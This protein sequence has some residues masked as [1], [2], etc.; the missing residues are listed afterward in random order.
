MVETAQ[1]A[2]EFANP[3]LLQESRV[4]SHVPAN[5]S[6]TRIER[7]FSEV[8]H[9][10]DHGQL[11]TAIR[12]ADS[13]RRFTPRNPT[14]ALLYARLLLPGGA[15]AEAIEALAPFD[16]PDVIVVR[17]EALCA[18]GRWNEAVDLCETVLCKFA[19]D[20][21]EH[22]QAFAGLMCSS[23]Q[24]PR[25]SGW[26]GLDS[27]LK[28]IGEVSRGSQLNLRIGGKV[29]QP[30]ILRDSRAR[31]DS[32][33]LQLPP[34]STGIVTAC[35]NGSQL[36]G[37]G[38]T[39]PVDFASGG[40]VYRDGTSIHGEVRC[41]WAPTLPL[42]LA[43]RSGGDLPDRLWLIDPSC[44]GA[45]LLHSVPA[46]SVLPF[47]I[48]LTSAEIALP[49]VE[50]FLVLPDESL[51]PLLGS[52]VETPAPSAAL[53]LQ[54]PPREA[55]DGPEH[56]RPILDIVIPVYSGYDETL[57]CL[58]SVWA[59]TGSDSVEMVVV[60]DASPDPR[61]CELLEQW[62]RDGRI[63]LL[64]NP[65]NRGFPSSANR[66][67]RLHGDRDVVLLNSDT[68]VFD[69]WLERLKRAAYRAED[70]GTVTPLGK[71]DSITDYSLMGND[72]SAASIDR[73]AREVNADKVVELP[74]GVGF[75]LLVRRDCLAETG[76]FDEVNFGRGYGEENDFC[77]RASDRGWRHLAAT[78]VFIEHQG[79]RSFGMAREALLARNGRVLNLLHPGYD[80]LIDEFTAGNSL[81]S[82]R[83]AI[84]IRLLLDQGKP[85]V[86]LT[87]LQL[88]GGVKRHVDQRSL[89]L[90]AAGHTVLVLRPSENRAPPGRVFFSVESLGLKDLIFD[91]SRDS[92]IL[93]EMLQELGLEYIEIH[94]LLDMPS[95][96][97]DLLTGLG[98]PYHV[99]I[100]DYSWICPRLTLVGGNGLYCG[101]PS[102]DQCE[103][104]IQT[105]GSEMDGSVTVEELRLRSARI[106]GRA[107]SVIAP[108]RDAHDRLARYFPN[109]DVKIVPWEAV[110]RSTARVVRVEATLRV[111]ILGAISLQKGHQILLDC[112]RDAA[113]RDLNLEFVVIGYTYDDEPLL[114]TGKVFV[115]GPYREE[116]INSLLDRER[117][118]LA[119]FSSVSPETWCYTLTYAMA[120]GLPIVAFD[121][122]AVAE[123]LL[124]FSAA[125]LLQLSSTPANINDSLLSFM[126][127][128]S[129]SEKQ[130]EAAME[131]CA[132]SAAQ[133]PE[134]E[135]GASVQALSLPEGI[136]SFSVQGGPT[137]PLEAE[138]LALPAL[139]VGVAPAKNPGN[140]EFLTKATALDGWLV[141]ETDMIILKISGGNASLLLTSLR[142][143]DSP[144]LNVDVRRLAV[145]AGSPENEAKNG[146]LESGSIESGFVQ[147]ASG[148]EVQILTHIKNI[149]DLKFI[150]G[151]AG[152]VGQKLW[153]EAFAVIAAGDIRPDLI[154][155]RAVTAEGLETPWLSNQLLCGSRGVGMPIVS[156]AVR[157][158]PE[159]ASQYDCVY[160]G[161][162]LSGAIVGPLT[163]SELCSSE[164][165]G[166]PLEAMELRV[167]PREGPP[168]APSRP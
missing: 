126:E 100:H 21:I 78:D 77:L 86:L 156:Y 12:L 166:D 58:E 95:D 30:A 22:L 71:A 87:T 45:G 165:P 23:E 152:W 164:V 42:T 105:H 15:P 155:Y 7:I 93:L 29:Y 40:W 34:G 11:S 162:F 24:G 49:Q 64:V 120:Y 149:G 4:P 145:E 150:D 157:L 18:L 66:G 140:V 168:A 136:Y 43:I 62:A 143:P 46:F 79:G 28:L 147:S 84:D 75:C 35:A 101:E 59:T 72:T 91:L 41:S 25:Y 48:P 37:S 80:K 139:Q 108:S 167:T 52:P 158:K 99:Y 56:V 112:A 38:L 31:L 163:D 102:V 142:T 82:A 109:L 107:N 123:R 63:T 10:I 106:L 68:E 146:S 60:N 44:V 57:A 9:A 47:S 115:T 27:K 103:A 19:A 134:Q 69:D 135:L 121:H 76:F 70:I 51:A 8:A 33:A 3:E 97:V 2:W 89:E 131:Q 88:P 50:V 20:S 13:A 119:F 153:I 90:A 81:L 130:M 161:K 141:Y 61:I 14:C 133:A 117:C 83:R 144:V 16:G 94:H 114:A 36:L 160:S 85:A 104:C 67:M 32:F 122:G 124:P 73:I 132:A 96:V 26:I 148:R 1:C 127:E 154:E 129:T 6:S 53:T 74:V 98:V 65:S 39:L 159:V 111:A 110:P 92:Q 151:W 55:F 113:Q 138:Q 118:H 17:G 116:E 5:T 137:R 128:L 125:K 54:P